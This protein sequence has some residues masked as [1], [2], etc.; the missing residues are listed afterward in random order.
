MELTRDNPGVPAFEDGGFRLF[1]AFAMMLNVFGYI[2]IPDTA[3]R[4][5]SSNPPPPAQP[6]PWQAP[7]SVPD[8]EEFI[9]GVRLDLAK[10]PAGC[11]HCPLRR[12]TGW[13]AIGAT[14]VFSLDVT[15]GAADRPET[16]FRP[17]LL[18]PR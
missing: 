2:H 10:L 11:H 12:Q 3:A 15:D 9:S 6:Q 14:A 16:T 1:E 18:R 8:L 7:Q 17:K 5:G 13:I 4:E